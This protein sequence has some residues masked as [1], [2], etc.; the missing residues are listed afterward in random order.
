MIKILQSHCELLPVGDCPQHHRSS[1]DK[2][3][4]QGIRLAKLT[5]EFDSGAINFI[6]FGG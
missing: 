2:G 5:E 4:R 1:H 6:K 3:T